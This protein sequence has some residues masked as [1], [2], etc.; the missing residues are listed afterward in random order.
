MLNKQQTEEDV[1][2]L[3]EP[4]GVIEECTVL[5]GPD[6][7]SKGCAFV[8]FSTHT[9]AQSAISGLH[10]SQTMPGASSSLVVKFADTDK[11]RTIR[12]M[13]QMVGPVWHLQPTISPA[14]QHLQQHLQYLHARGE[15]TSLKNQTLCAFA[16]YGV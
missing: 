11:E 6:G 2:R 15:H 5:R 13:Q 3:F 10:G 8:K 14:V 9:E 1:Y 16:P 7:N 12:R 4:Y